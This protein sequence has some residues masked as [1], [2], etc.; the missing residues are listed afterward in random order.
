MKE[1]LNE[2]G[3]IANCTG[4]NVHNDLAWNK[5]ELFKS[6]QNKLRLYQAAW[7]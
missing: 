6:F 3:R 7:I 1:G 5:V 4:F 2:A